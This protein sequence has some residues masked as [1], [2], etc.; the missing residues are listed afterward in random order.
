MLLAGYGQ[1]ATS[2]SS[3]VPGLN[4]YIIIVLTNLKFLCYILFDSLI[5][6]LHYWDIAFKGMV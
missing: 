5:D 6:I 3:L 2:R 1:V 4:N